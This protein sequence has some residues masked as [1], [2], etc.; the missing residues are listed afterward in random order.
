MTTRSKMRR[1]HLTVPALAILSAVAVMAAPPLA[2]AQ[3]SGAEVTFTKDIA[4]ILQRSCQNCHRPDGGAPMSL[5]TYEDVRPWARSIK[6][7]TGLRN[8]ADAMPPWYIEKDIGIQAFKGDISLSDAEV[9]NI[10]TWVDNGAPRGNP[11]DMPPPLTFLDASLW[12]IGEPDMIVSSPN[13][14]VGASDPDWWGHIGE[15]EITLTEDR[16][17]A[18][19]EMKEVNNREPTTARATVGSRFAIHHLVWSAVHDDQLSPEEMQ[20]L[21]TE[22]PDEFERVAAESVGQGFWPVHEVGRNADYFDPKA[23]M[24]LRAGSRLSFSSAHMHSTGSHTT[25][26]LDIAF[27]FH[28]RGYKPEYTNQSAVRGDA[29][30]R[31]EGKHGEPEDRIVPDHAAE[32][33]ADVVRA[34]PARRGRPDVS[35]CDLPQRAERDVELFRLQP[36]L[37]QGLSLRRPRG[38]ADPEGYDPAHHGVLRHHGRKQERRRREELVG[39][40]AQVDRPD[41]D[42]PHPGDISHRRAVCPRV[43]RATTGSQSAAWGICVLGCPGCSDIPVE[44]SADQDQ[45]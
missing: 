13:V 25:T 33:E 4:P 20:R 10:A 21:R 7:R 43:G 5:L 23:G 6:N 8:T 17:V 12:Q 9:E 24:K 14:E 31:C 22:D 44:T 32:C 45:Q 15:S 19:V 26:R 29:E 1:I 37:G 39:S 28:P 35:G 42:Q 16:Y 36:Q 27:K 11:A 3:G 40:W 2:V 30:H 18:A 41:A 38:T 34:T